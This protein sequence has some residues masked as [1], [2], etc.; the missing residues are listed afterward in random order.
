LGQTAEANATTAD[1]QWY[2]IVWLGADNNQGW[3]ASTLVAAEN[4]QD[5]P[6]V[7]PPTLPTE[8][9]TEIPP[10]PIPPTSTFPPEAVQPIE[11]TATVEAV[12]PI[13]PT[14]TIPGSGG[15]TSWLRRRDGLRIGRTASRFVVGWPGVASQ[16]AMAK[17]R[18]MIS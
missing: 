6:V 5:L 10:T 8:M 4:I 13:A 17:E 16:A 14:P 3:V 7:Q 11:P 12:Q 1:S 2:G 15:G 9:P 18:P